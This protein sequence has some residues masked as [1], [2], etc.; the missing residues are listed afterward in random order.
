MLM[1]IVTYTDKEYG[2]GGDDNSGSE[3]DDDDDD[4][5]GMIKVNQNEDY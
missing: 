3:N 5:D 2:D 4:D 1:S